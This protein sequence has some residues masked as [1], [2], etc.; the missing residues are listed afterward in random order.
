MSVY[1]D[2]AQDAGFYGA[3]ATQMAA[4]LEAEHQREILDRDEQ[5]FAYEQKMLL[6]ADA[7][8]LVH[9]TEQERPDLLASLDAGLQQTLCA[10]RDDAY[11][12]EEDLLD[13]VG[14]LHRELTFLDE[15]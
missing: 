5:R 13:L 4:M 3:D 2:M 1:S 7:Q 6:L 8:D 14:V 15:Q 10:V 12:T 9:R 11:A